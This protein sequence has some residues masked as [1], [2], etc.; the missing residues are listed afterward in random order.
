MEI[1][2]YKA[3]VEAGVKQETAENLVGS[4]ERE[5]KE[6]LKETRT[7]LATK[8]DIALL[9][10]EMN[11]NKAEVIKWNVGTILAAAALAMAIARFMG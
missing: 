1:Q 7:D 6:R 8:E 4:F 9:K 11:N 2:L 3:L 5:L 10:A